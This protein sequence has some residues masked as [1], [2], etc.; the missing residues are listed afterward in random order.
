[1]ENREG[2]T[3][4]IEVTVL[5]VKERELPEADDDFAQIASQFDT[6]KELRDDLKKQA[7]RK[8]VFTQAQEAREQAGRE[9]DFRGLHASSAGR[10]GC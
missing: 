7:Q 5:S 8:G 10:G 1:M 6:I 9:D 4:L 2:E 3:A